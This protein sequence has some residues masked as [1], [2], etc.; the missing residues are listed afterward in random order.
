MA[1]L[2]IQQRKN[3]D[4][5]PKAG[6]LIEIR[7]FQEL[8]LHDRRVF[9]LLIEHA[10][11]E[12]GEDKDHEIPMRLLRGPRHNGKERVG[13]SIRQLMT[14][15]VEVRLIDKDGRPRL[16]ETTLLSQDDRPLDEDDPHGVVFYRFSPLLR[17]IILQSRYWGRIKASIMFA[18]SSKYALALYEAVCLRA[19]R[20]ACEECFSVEE[21]R[22][23]LDVG[24]G[25]LLQ[26]FNLMKWAIDPAVTEVNALSNFNVMIDPIRSGGGVRG[27]MIGF[28]LYWSRKSPEEWRVVLSELGRP[29]VGRKAR[30]KERAGQTLS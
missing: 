7:P 22:D 29:R 17:R 12:I 2:T 24:E 10:G 8:S 9:N 1:S 11:P 18:F 25:K 15:I 28:R 6:E 20:Q 4:G 13:D 27:Q 21:L 5:F 14:T 30:I 26:S 19:N 3:K 23:L 16:R